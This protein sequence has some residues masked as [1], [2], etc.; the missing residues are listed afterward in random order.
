MFIDLDVE[1]GHRFQFFTSTV[2]PKTNEPVYEDPAGDMYFTIRSMAPYFE[3]YNLKRK[4]LV[5]VVLNPKTRSMERITY[6]PELT[7][8]ESRSQME[9]AWDWAIMDFEG[10]KD[11]TTKEIV[12]VTLA[13]KIRM[14]KNP[15]VNRFLTRCFQII[16]EGSVVSEETATKNSLPGSSGTTINHDPGSKKKMERS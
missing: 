10:A 9:G 8:E 7:E 16:D 12:S 5:D 2:D 3:A 4:K 1:V 6:L 13:N 11:K 15:M 14:S